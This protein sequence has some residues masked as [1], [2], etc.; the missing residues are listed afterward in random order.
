[1]LAQRRAT[2]SSLIGMPEVEV[3]SRFGIPARS[4]E[5][6][7]ARVLEYQRLDAYRVP[8]APGIPGWAEF[9]CTTT[10]IIRRGQVSAFDLQ[11]NGCNS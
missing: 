3:I 7:G 10:F 8:G 11:G 1:V 6:N 9:R 2:L 4:Y 5:Q